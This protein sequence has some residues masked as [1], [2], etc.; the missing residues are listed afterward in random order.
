MLKTSKLYTN[1]TTLLFREHFSFFANLATKSESQ[2]KSEGL[3]SDFPPV[4][5]E[6][7]KSSIEKE[8]KGKP[9]DSLIWKTDEGFEVHPFYTKEDASP[10]P[11][12]SFRAKSD[13]E[14]YEDFIVENV[15]TSNKNA[16][17]ALNRG[18][19]SLNFIFKKNSSAAELELL[20]KDIL[21]EFISINFT[22][23]KNPLQLLNWFKKIILQRKIDSQKIS[24]ALIFNPFENKKFR[25]ET[26]EAI[27]NLSGFSPLFRCVTIS[28]L[29]EKLITKQIGN[30]LNGGKIILKK[31]VD[32]KVAIDEAAARIQFSL[33][34][35]D[36]YFFE[37]AKI[38][39]MRILWAKIVERFKPRHECSLITFI[40]SEIIFSLPHAPF[41][42]D[43]HDRFISY[44]SRVMSAAIGG[45]DSISI[46]SEDEFS[47]RINRNIQL[48]AKE[49]SY[50]N[51]VNDAGAGSYYIEKLTD[52]IADKAWGEVPDIFL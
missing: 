35:S 39:A 50:M 11:K 14:I 38:R 45:A 8:L 32:N 2:M 5:K 4:S 51:Q 26:I 49:E 16:L 24:G 42:A 37:I 40:H 28:S 17:D 19:N 22:C 31:L 23:E 7:W 25:T 44:T 6:K 33:P 43:K 20:L 12:H 10:S 47:K 27:N 18:T 52:L 3:F 13:W 21:P 46:N 30:A 9:F 36:N 15:K 29:N 34:V 48:I 1:L 41:T